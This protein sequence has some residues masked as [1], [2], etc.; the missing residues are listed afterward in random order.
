MR[1][2]ER[3]L[4]LASCAEYQD[5]ALRGPHNEGCR[6]G[7]EVSLRECEVG[8]VTV[9]SARGGM[10]GEVMCAIEVMCRHGCD[11]SRTLASRRRPTVQ[12][13]RQREREKAGTHI[14]A[15]KQDIRGAR[16][17]RSNTRLPG[18]TPQRERERERWDSDGAQRT[19]EHD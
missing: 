2:R 6:C 10:G 14:S 19:D 12:R 9:L 7:G 13:Q 4:G 11:Q 3:R 5:D 15:V 16:P 1:L 18:T 8:Q 17:N